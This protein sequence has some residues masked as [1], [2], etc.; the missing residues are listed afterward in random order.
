MNLSAHFSLEELVASQVATRQGISNAPPGKVIANLHRV[1]DALEKVRQLVLAPIYV[2]SGY[3]SP[4]LNQAVGGASNSA[5]VLGLAADFTAA[6]WTPR[7]L[8]L[9]IAESDIE[10]DQ[11]IYEGTWV[12]LGLSEASARRQLLT[13]V[14]KGGR[15][16]YQT[17]IA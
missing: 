10:F 13:A 7:A 4:A 9:K 16:S 14:F 8:A 3:R 12:H 1:A 17:G 6:G 11:L 2:S 5:H 15:A